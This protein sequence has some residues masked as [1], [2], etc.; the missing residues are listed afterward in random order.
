MMQPHVHPYYGHVPFP[1]LQPYHNYPFMYAL[2]PPIL[3]PYPY[4]GYLHTYYTPLLC[5]CHLRPNSPPRSYVYIPEAEE[6]SNHSNSPPRS[7]VYIPEA[8][9]GSNQP[10]EG[11]EEKERAG[12]EGCEA[13]ARWEGEPRS[14]VRDDEDGEHVKLESRGRRAVEGLQ[15][16]SAEETGRRHQESQSASRWQVDEQE[17]G[18]GL[19]SRWGRDLG[20]RGIRG[21]PRG[22]DRL[23]EQRPSRRER[24]SSW[25]ERMGAVGNGIRLA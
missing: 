25:R 2:P 6:G 15:A 23:R 4:G 13:R 8:E 19:W 14:E 5:A 3:H 20:A 1:Y 9:E 18:S 12:G 21:R 24:T 11:E 22:R 16:R 7:S 17:A 10:L